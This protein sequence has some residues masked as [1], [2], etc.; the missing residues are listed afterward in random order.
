MNSIPDMRSEIDKLDEEIIALV[1]QR[2]E[3]SRQIGKVRSSVGGPRIVA[4]RESEI[5]QRYIALGDQGDAIAS[6][7]LR[8]GRGLDEPATA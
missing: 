4:D 2:T 5:R 1:R 8:L 6:A 3:I 7:L